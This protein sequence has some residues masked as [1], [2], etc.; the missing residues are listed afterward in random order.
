MS[1]EIRT[2]HRISPIKSSLANII[3]LKTGVI[4]TA[5]YSLLIACMILVGLFALQQSGTHRVGFIFA[6]IL[7][8]WLLCVAGI[9][10]YN[11]IQW[12][13]RVVYAVSPH[14][15]YNFF[16]ADGRHGWRSLGGIVL[17]VTGS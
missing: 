12:N 13:P 3:T 9:G 8:A 4:A 1:Q 15:I 11:V 10:F 16:K 2:Q 6:P 5:D 14:Y 7:T 17:C